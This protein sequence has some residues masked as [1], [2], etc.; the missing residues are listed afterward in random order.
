MAQ[1]FQTYHRTVKLPCEVVE[2]GRVHK[3]ELDASVLE[4]ARSLADVN[5]ELQCEAG[6]DAA[7]HLN[8]T[9]KTKVYTVSLQT[10]FGQNVA[11]SSGERRTFISYSISAESRVP[12]LDRA[13][14]AAERLAIM[15]M[16][17]GGLAGATVVFAGVDAMLNAFHHAVIPRGLIAIAIIFG[18]WCGGKL[19]H[20]LG[21]VLESY[22]INRAEA[23]GVTDEADSL[24][25]TL[26]QKLDTITS[27][28]ERV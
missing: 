1:P 25:N 5:K 28:Y 7:G 20:R 9:L 14:D 16:I 6:D 24:W 8:A 13:S 15:L 19:G 12:A 22:A 11:Y 27:R 26:T 2:K 21:A 23:R 4:A 18:G 10:Q 3:N 17:A